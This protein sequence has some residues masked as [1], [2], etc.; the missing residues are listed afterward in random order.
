MFSAGHA[1][2]KNHNSDEQ[3]SEADLDKDV[4]IID[5][6]SL[7][8]LRPGRRKR[9]R[10]RVDELVGNRRGVIQETVRPCVSGLWTRRCPFS[11]AVTLL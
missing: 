2:L 4:E 9:A 10:H 3:R 5:P 11:T 8:L 1:H 7:L 6:L